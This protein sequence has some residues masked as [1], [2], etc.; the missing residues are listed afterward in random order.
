[1]R[2]IR[3]PRRP[4]WLGPRPAPSSGSSFTGSFTSSFMLCVPIHPWRLL[5][6]EFVVEHG[7]QLVVRCGFEVLLRR[8]LAGGGVPPAAQQRLQAGG[9][10]GGVGAVAGAVQGR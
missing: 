6:G 5:V 2:C 1:K 4:D 9:D 3:S 10:G 7:E 8:L